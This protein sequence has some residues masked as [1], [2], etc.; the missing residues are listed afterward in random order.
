[1]AKGRPRQGTQRT[2]AV[3]I[4]LDPKLRYLLDIAARAHRRTISGF[5]DWAISEQIKY[6]HV[7]R[8]GRRRSV[9]EVADTLW[10]TDPD[11]RFRLLATQ[12]PELLIYDEQVRLKKEAANG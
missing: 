8:D 4:R 10:S 11:E 1:M 5:I 7:G 2:A 3:S 6:V 9:A 12:Y